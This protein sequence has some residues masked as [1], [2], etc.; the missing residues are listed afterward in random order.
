MGKYAIKFF[1]NSLRRSFLEIKITNIAFPYRHILLGIALKHHNPIE[2]KA[3]N[4]DD[5]ITKQKYLN[6]CRTWLKIEEKKGKKNK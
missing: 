6:Y 2:K 5:M 4:K 3:Q 1:N